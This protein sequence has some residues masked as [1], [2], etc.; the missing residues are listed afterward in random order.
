ML[1]SGQPARR[2]PHCVPFGLQLATACALLARTVTTTGAVPTT[3]VA[4]LRK[5]RRSSDPGFGLVTAAPLVRILAK[6]LGGSSDSD[7]G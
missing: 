6:I 1:G 5:S 4:R 3:I 2:V 7:K